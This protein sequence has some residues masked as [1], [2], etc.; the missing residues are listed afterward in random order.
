MGQNTT[1]KTVPTWK[2]YNR[3]WYQKLGLAIW[4]YIRNVG[5]MLWGVIKRIPTAIWH[6]IKA[7]GLCFYGLWT[8]FVNGDWR[9][10]ISYL[11]F[12]F[13]CF[14]RSPKQW[15]KGFLLLAFEALFIVYMIFIGVPNLRMMGTL[16]ITPQKP[17]DNGI[18]FTTVYDDSMEILIFSVMTI[19]FLIFFAYMYVKNTKIAY[20]TQ[21]RVEAGKALTGPKQQLNYALNDGYHT[22]VL[23]LPI[24]GVLLITVLP[25]TVNILVA[26]TNY[27]Y[28]HLPPKELFH[29][30]GFDAF[31][32]L[33]GKDFGSALWSVLGWT[34]IWAVFSTLSLIHN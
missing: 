7:V 3:P 27:D 30:V 13:G 20:E 34:L 15:L 16:G 33:F 29:W 22:T 17:N 5:L 19:F 1:V 4:N 32:N 14:S 9:T 12:G 2:K 18:G 26:F 24:L 31:A 11:I 23:T 25:L 8:R 21:K 6:F 28:L 10:K